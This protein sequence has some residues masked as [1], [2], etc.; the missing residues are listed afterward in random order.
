MNKRKFSISRLINKGEDIGLK[1][2]QIIEF[3]E[4]YGAEAARDAF[5]VARS[6]LFLWKKRLREGGIT[7]LPCCPVQEPLAAIGKQNGIPR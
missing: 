3:F 7:P 5:G 2:S 6:T 1:K 4:K